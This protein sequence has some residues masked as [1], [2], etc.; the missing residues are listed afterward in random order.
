MKVL[1]IFLFVSLI[2]VMGCDRKSKATQVAPEVEVITLTSSNVAVPHEYICEINAVQ[3]VEVRARVQGYLEEIFIDEGQ[4]VKKGQP[5]FRI[6]SNEYK[7][8]VTKAEANLRRVIAEAKTKSLDEDRVKLMV[9]K[10]VISPTEL[11][12]AQARSEAAESGI[13]EAKSV[14]ENARTNLGYTSIVS[15]FKGTVDRIPFKKGSLISSGSLLTSVTNTEQVFA[16]FRVSETEYLQFVKKN[17]AGRSPNIRQK[18]RLILAD[19][20][21]YRHEG[22]VE[23]MEGDFDRSTGSIAFRARFPNPEMILKHGSSGTI[24]L[25]KEWRDAILIPQESAFTIQDKYYV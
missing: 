4:T 14:L 17:S 19:G 7:E 1:L 13:A 12:V 8:T 15:P 5:L 9:E 22:V 23:T 16:Y 24:Q 25:D 21:M 11:E 2:G 6:S 20:S 10:N 3:Y 18:V